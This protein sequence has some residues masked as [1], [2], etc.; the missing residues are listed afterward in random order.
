[1][2]PLGYLVLRLFFGGIFAL[3]GIQQLGWLDGNGL[4][5]NGTATGAALAFK[6]PTPD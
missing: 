5:G 3:H 2:E 6:K 4:K 1:M